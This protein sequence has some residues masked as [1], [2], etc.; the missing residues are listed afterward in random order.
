[1]NKPPRYHV[2]PS[3]ATFIYMDA[4][5]R[6]VWA[7]GDEPHPTDEDGTPLEFY[8][9]EFGPRALSPLM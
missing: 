1:M 9:I 8:C 7:S 3:N 2:S 6:E 5:G 4:Q